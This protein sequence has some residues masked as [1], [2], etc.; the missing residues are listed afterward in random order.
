MTEKM[1]SD[2]NRKVL[3]ETPWELYQK[4]GE[5]SGLDDDTLLKYMP[6]AAVAALNETPEGDFERDRWTEQARAYVVMSMEWMNRLTS[7]NVRLEAQIQVMQATI[8]KFKKKRGG[9]ILPG[10]Q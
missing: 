4:P 3:T 2:Q 5:A 7:Y 10:E 9:L 6:V 8:K 1:D